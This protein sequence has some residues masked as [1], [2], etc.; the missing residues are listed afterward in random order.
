MS[1]FNNSL[2]SNKDK[3]TKYQCMQVSYNSYFY[4]NRGNFK[5]YRLYF[6]LNNYY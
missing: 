1:I 2:E 6:N 5:L 4:V 3:I